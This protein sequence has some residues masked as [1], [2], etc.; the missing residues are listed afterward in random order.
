MRPELWEQRVERVKEC[1]AAGF[2]QTE[3]ANFL[4]ITATTV[5]TYAKRA[6][7]P[8]PTSAVNL[9]S[10]RDCA[11]RGLTRAETAAELG[12]SVATVGQY[13]REYAIPF[14]HAGTSMNDARSEP[15]A[16]MYKAG[17]TLEEIGAVYSVTRERV[18]Q[19][20]KKYHGIVG[21]DGGQSARAVTRKQSAEAK[22]NA[23]FMARYGCSFADYQSFASLSKEMRA[24][25]STYGKAVLGAYRAQE[26]S[27]KR[28]GIEW[29][30]TILEWWDIWQKSGK[31]EQRGRGQGYMMCRFGDA[32]YY[33]TG[34][35]Y[36]A[37]G[38]HN[39]TVQPNNPYR[40]NHPDH[41]EVVQRLRRGGH[42]K[43]DKPLHRVN[44]GLPKGVTI[45]HGRFQAQAS[46]GGKNKY[47]GTFPTPEA[48]HHA[49]VAAISTLLEV[50]A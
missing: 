18:R 12:L 34:N 6:S 14:R 47:L 17:K 42:R 40:K 5:R 15:M 31:W 43:T 11:S 48:A 45:R 7:L 21:K 36:I 37:T 25:G 3:T 4:G 44:I 29:N 38:I 50:V 1:F 24:N 49:Y 10:I 13:G 35:V 20:L 23:K 19:I 16:A 26:R 46:I 9:N 33:A 30:L 32:G 8:V 22:K 28:R 2:N 41:A 27:A 39:G